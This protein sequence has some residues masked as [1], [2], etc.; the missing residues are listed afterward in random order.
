[1]DDTRRPHAFTRTPMLLIVM[2]LPSPDTTPPQTTMYFIPL[3]TARGRQKEKGSFT[4]KSKF[5]ASIVLPSHV[6]LD[7]HRARRRPTIF[8]YREYMYGSPML[9]IVANL[10]H[11]LLCHARKHSTHTP[12]SL[13][14]PGLLRIPYALSSPYYNPL[15]AAPPACSVLHACQLEL[16]RASLPSISF[17]TQR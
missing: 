9:N 7:P 8:Y 11:D 16:L 3:T 13:A 14:A 5:S 10:L 15:S 2:P 17:A 1:M 6:T 12:R 4:A